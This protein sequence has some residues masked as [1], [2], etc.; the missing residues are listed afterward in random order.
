[1]SIK[2]SA[3]ELQKRWSAIDQKFRVKLAK[4]FSNGDA[5]GWL[6]HFVRNQK[7]LLHQYHSDSQKRK[8]TSI[9]TGGFF[10]AISKGCIPAKVMANVVF[11]RVA[12]QN[13]SHSKVELLGIQPNATR[14]DKTLVYFRF[15]RFDQS[16]NIFESGIGYY[17]LL[18]KGNDWLIEEM[19]LFE[20]DNSIAE[21]VDLSEMWKP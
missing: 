12:K 20:D 5:E 18:K 11:R 10:K 1:M 4:D 3:S 7:V 6:A 2:L 16:G 19:S 13:F 21:L 8:T 17:D 14:E 9:H 15:Q